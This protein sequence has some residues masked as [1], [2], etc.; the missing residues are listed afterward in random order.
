MNGRVENEE[1]NHDNAEEPGDVAVGHLADPVR[2][3]DGIVSQLQLFTQRRH[4]VL[5]RSFPKV[6]L[7]RRKALEN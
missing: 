1:R 6:E 5:R 4:P 3:P 2:P 7:Q